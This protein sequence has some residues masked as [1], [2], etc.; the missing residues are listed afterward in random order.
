MFERNRPRY[1]CARLEQGSSRI[2]RFLNFL[3]FSAGLHLVRLLDNPG[4]ITVPTCFGAMHEVDD[5]APFLECG[6]QCSEYGRVSRR[7]LVHY[8]CEYT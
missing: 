3:T 2:S 4:P 6:I 7:R 5:A 1:R 8:G